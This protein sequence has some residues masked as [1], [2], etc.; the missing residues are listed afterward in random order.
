VYSA[1]A[2]FRVNEAGGGCGSIYRFHSG[3]KAGYV[4]CDVKCDA[5]D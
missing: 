5:V 1:V 2:I 4:K 3:S